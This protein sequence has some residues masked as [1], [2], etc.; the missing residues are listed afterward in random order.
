L[1]ASG[2]V[3]I[4]GGCTS[5]L[6]GFLLGLPLTMARM[7]SPTASRHLVTAHLASIIQGATLVA[8][9]SVMDV[10]DL[11]HAIETLAAVLLVA[12]AVLFVA[13]ALAN[14][15]QNVEDH[16]ATRSIG[17][18]LFATSGPVNITGAITVLIGVLRGL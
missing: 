7:K 3:L 15:R 2:E 16:F 8:L 17:W 10:S 11:P 18:K 14:W 6:Y 9:A 12:G 1:D 4:V 5:I 13:G